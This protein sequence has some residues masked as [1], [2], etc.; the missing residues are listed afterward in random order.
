MVSDLDSHHYKVVNYLHGLTRQ[1]IRHLGGALGLMY[2][3][4]EKMSDYP[5][6]MVAAWLRKEDNV[7]PESGEPSW[8]SLVQALKKI[9]QEGVAGK[10][11]T[12]A[13]S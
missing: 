12:E 4:L 6:D 3:T 9:G 5:D 7:I 10:I 13:V 1:Q 2:S 8:R 11:E